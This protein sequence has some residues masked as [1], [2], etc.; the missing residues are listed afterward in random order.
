MSQLS[1]TISRWQGAGL[2]ATTLLGT[3]VFILPQMTIAIA[4]SGAILAWALLTMAIIPIT[5]VFA[6]LASHFPHAAGPAYFVEKAFGN[7]AGRC[8]GLSFLLLIPMGSAAAILITFKFLYVLVPLTGIQELLA[9]LA[10]IALLLAI[11]VKGIQVSAK[12]QFFLTLSILAIVVALLIVAGFNSQPQKLSV[13]LQDAEFGPVLSAAGVAFWSFLG[14]EAMTHLANDFRDPK[15]DLVPAMMIGTILVGVIYIACTYLLIITPFESSLAMV[16]V[17]D[18]LLGGYGAQVIGVLGAASGLAVVNVYS[19]GISRLIW[20]FSKEQ[21]LPKYFDKLNQHQVPVRA[22]VANLL[23]MAL[24]IIFTYFSGQELEQLISWTNG[25]FVVIY[26]ATM[27]AAVKLL[28]KKYLPLIACSLAFCVA[29]AISLGSSMIYAF[30]ILVVLIPSLLWQRSH[31]TQ[32]R[33]YTHT[34]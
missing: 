25:V 33:A 12:L 20:S 26:S 10:M 22:L 2:M 16:D 14:V 4:N 28:S 7:I 18:Q 31:L 21:V 24:A 19:A 9:Q 3:G 15:K 23:T 17:F 32:N 8:I 30:I 11:N 29:V 1:G 27:F 6:R 5:L 34:E 13:I